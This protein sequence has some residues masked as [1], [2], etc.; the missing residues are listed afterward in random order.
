MTHEDA[1]IFVGQYLQVYRMIVYVVRYHAPLKVLTVRSART[2]H[3]ESIK[4]EDIQA[5]I[6]AGH[7]RVMTEYRR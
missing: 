7:I 2:L 4:T 6:D 5:G 3:E 1:R